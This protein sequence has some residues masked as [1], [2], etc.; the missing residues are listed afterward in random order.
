MWDTGEISSYKKNIDLV[1]FAVQRGFKIDR[2]ESWKGST[3]L[4]NGGEKICVKRDPNGAYLYFSFS[5]P[6]DHGT[7]FDFLKFRGGG[8]FMDVLKYLREWTGNPKPSF[9][10]PEKSTA[11]ITQEGQP[12]RHC[13]TPV[14]R[15][16]EKK[17]PKK[18]NPGGYY[19]AW[20]LICP[21]RKCRAIYLQEEAKRFYDSPTVRAPETDAY[22]RAPAA[23]ML[24][25][26]DPHAPFSTAD[27]YVPWIPEGGWESRVNKLPWE[28]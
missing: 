26:P 21:N 17:N 7:I 5:D 4:R 13:G 14:T 16:R 3:M 27:R 19:Y 10:K 1:D 11:R 9:S 18:R 25:K 8:M 2:A 20:S 28:D 12:C 24:P 6:R 22:D 23:A 15:T